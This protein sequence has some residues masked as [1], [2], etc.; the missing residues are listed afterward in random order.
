MNANLLLNMFI[1]LLMFMFHVQRENL[2][3]AVKPQ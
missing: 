2:N 1:E 3:T